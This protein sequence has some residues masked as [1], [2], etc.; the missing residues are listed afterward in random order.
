MYFCS[1]V[2]SL[3]KVPALLMR[4][5]SCA[6]CTGVRTSMSMC[7]TPI[8]FTATTMSHYNGDN[9]MAAAIS[10]SLLHAIRF[11]MLFATKEQHTKEGDKWSLAEIHNTKTVMVFSEKFSLYCKTRKKLE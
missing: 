11:V 8:F 3:I 6:Y 1:T 5:P 7:T 10:C 4:H 2:A 9:N